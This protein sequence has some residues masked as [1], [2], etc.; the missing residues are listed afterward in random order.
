M[1]LYQ[2][3]PEYT[4]YRE[5]QISSLLDLILTNEEGMVSNIQYVS[6]LC[7]SD[8][9]CLLFNTNLYSSTVENIKPRYA[10]HRGNYENMNENLKQI[11]WY[12]RLENIKCRKCL[13]IC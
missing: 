4:P 9:V 7:K 5:G 2:H 1:C 12:K 11:D 3:I 8:H 6:P 13:C 10:Y